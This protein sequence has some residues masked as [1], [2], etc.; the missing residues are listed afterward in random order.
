MG[1]WLYI[2]HILSLFTYLLTTSVS[3]RV[4]G[5][6]SYYSAG[7]RVINYPDTAALMMMTS[8]LLS[9]RGCWRMNRVDASRQR[10]PL[11]TRSSAAS[12]SARRH[13]CEDCEGLDWMLC[14]RQWTS[15]QCH[16][17][18]E[19]EGVSTGEGQEE[20]EVLREK[21]KGCASPC[22]PPLFVS[23]VKRHF[24]YIFKL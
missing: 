16:C 14:L 7:T 13:S 6:P 3:G 18:S 19:C 15:H 17:C 9:G 24:C 23:E 11:L 20:D 8:S 4:P 21:G 1:Y 22:P 10:A 2:G 12:R 5:Y